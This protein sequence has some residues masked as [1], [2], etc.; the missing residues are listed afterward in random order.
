MYNPMTAVITGLVT[1]CREQSINSLRDMVKST[2]IP[3]V[4]AWDHKKQKVISEVN[5][6]IG[7]SSCFMVVV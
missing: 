4:I 3:V 6:S 2:N 7:T 1:T 5:Q